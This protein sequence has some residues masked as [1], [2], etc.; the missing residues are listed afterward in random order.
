MVACHS[1]K[2][3][4]KHY[5]HH[6]MAEVMKVPVTTAALW[7]VSWRSFHAAAPHTVLQHKGSAA[8]KQ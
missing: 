1:L 3:I 4:D 8:P 7:S 2:L 5:M 6:H